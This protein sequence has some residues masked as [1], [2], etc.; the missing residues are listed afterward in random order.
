[1]AITGS[2]S[3]AQFAP[4]GWVQCRLPCSVTSKDGK[5]IKWRVIF[6]AKISFYLN[7]LLLVNLRYIWCNW[8]WAQ[9]SIENSIS[10]VVV[11]SQ[12]VSKSTR[13]ILNS[14]LSRCWPGLAT[15]I[16]KIF[17]NAIFICPNT[18]ELGVAG[19]GNAMQCA[20]VYKMSIKIS[21]FD[22]LFLV[23]FNLHDYDNIQ[24]MWNV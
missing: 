19:R 3:F 4:R 17:F 5:E 8:C 23:T 13:H 18:V 10:Q 20:Y 6:G 2:V 7:A 12:W 15:A 24:M 14:V 22:C 11:W 1:M 21:I 16:L 9:Y